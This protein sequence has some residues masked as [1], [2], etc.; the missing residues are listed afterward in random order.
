MKYYWRRC[1]FLN[2]FQYHEELKKLLPKNKENGNQNEFFT[3][4]VKE[5][6][7]SVE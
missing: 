7:K 4:R 5:I 2:K 3:S 1:I 6:I